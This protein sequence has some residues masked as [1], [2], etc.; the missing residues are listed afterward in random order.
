MSNSQKRPN[1][2]NLLDII[3]TEEDLQR[4]FKIAKFE[5]L[6]DGTFEEFKEEIGDPFDLTDS[7]N[8][9]LEEAYDIACEEDLFQGSF[10]QFVEFHQEAVDHD[11]INFA[12]EIFLKEWPIHPMVAVFIALPLEQT[13]FEEQFFTLN[14][15][16]I[17]ATSTPAEI[18]AI[19]RVCGVPAGVVARRILLYFFS[20]FYQD[21][22]F[23]LN[24]RV[25]SKQFINLFGYNTK[26]YRVQNPVIQ[27]FTRLTS[28]KFELSSLGDLIRAG[29][30]TIKQAYIAND[31]L[32]VDKTSIV[33]GREANIF[34]NPAFMFKAAFPVDFKHVKSTNKRSEFWNVYLLLVD[35]LP[36]IEP[37]K[38][39][40]VPW[41]TLEKIFCN[42][43]STLENFKYFFKKTLEDVIEIY[44]KSKGK[45]IT[46]NKDHVV[47]CHTP[48]PI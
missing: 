28:C 41:T 31:M 35:I 47:F 13:D 46:Q 22:L 40:Q 9:T 42:R 34:L 3:S 19:G 27:E 1:Y 45:V 29:Y 15:Y 48:A 23:E 10:E 18:F 30:K 25:D 21:E 44:P 4:S 5:G 17:K 43:Y 33:E 37:R 24:V 12:N 14:E 20:K 7:G 36:R 8:L 38:T 39:L 6:F 32:I 2:G 11:T 16:C 26:S